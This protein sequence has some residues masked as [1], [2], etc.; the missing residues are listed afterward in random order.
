MKQNNQT[1]D[2]NNQIF[3]DD[4]IIVFAAK[5]NGIEISQIDLAKCMDYL[6]K[7]PSKE[8]YPIVTN[9]L[10]RTI[11][12]FE[13]RM[14]KTT[15]VEAINNLSKFSSLLEKV[16]RF[17]E[18]ESIYRQAADIFKDIYGK[19]HLY[20]AM[21]LEDLA[22]LL[23]RYGKYY[24]AETLFRQALK[25][26]E[27][28]YGEDHP[29][30]TY[31]Q[32]RLANILMLL[33][34][35]SEA[36]K[37]YR[38]IISIREINYGDKN[39]DVALVLSDFATSLCCLGNYSE[40]VTLYER[41]LK[42]FEN[43]ANEPTAISMVLNRLS[44]NMLNLGRYLEAESYCRRAMKIDENIYYAEHP[45]IATHQH[46]L[47]NILMLLGNHSEAELICRRAL[48][49]RVKNY[50]FD[51]PAVANSLSDLSAILAKL[52]NFSEAETL[53]C[54]A[55]KIR[56]KVFGDQH[57]LVARSLLSYCQFMIN[58]GQLSSAIL[59]GKRAINI[60][61]NLRSEVTKISKRAQNHYDRKIENDYRTL[62]EVL[63]RANRLLEAEHILGLLKEEDF[64]DF[65]RRDSTHIDTMFSSISYNQEEATLIN[66]YNKISQSLFS[67][68]SRK[69]AF[70]EINIHSKEEA[71][72]LELQSQIVD[73]C[74]DFDNFFKKLNETFGPENAQS[75]DDA[76]QFIP[77]I[78]KLDAETAVIYTLSTEE[79][80]YTILVVGNTRHKMSYRISSDEFSKKVLRFRK[81]IMSRDKYDVESIA[82]ELYDIIL[83][84]LDPKLK[85]AGI[86]TI[87][88]VLEGA[89]R[90]LPV[91]ALHDGA[92]YIVNRFQNVYMTTKSR[93]NLE[94]Q[95]KSNWTA[96]GMGVTKAHENFKALPAVIEE[97]AGIV[98]HHNMTSGVVPGEILL[99][100]EFT[101]AA[102]TEELDGNYQAVHIASHFNLDPCN[103]TMSYLLLGDGTHLT[104][105]KLK[106]QKS[107]FCGVDLLAFSACSTGLGT[108][109][110]RGREID[111]IG[112]IAETQ[113]AKTV[114]A[115][116]WPVADQ[117]TSLLMRD[118]YK[119]RQEG[120]TKIEAL[121]QAQLGMLNRGNN[122]IGQHTTRSADNVYRFEVDR[123]K[124]YAHP[125][126]W[127][128]FIL[129][130]NYR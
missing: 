28:Y 125:Y 110:K 113:G 33:D 40:S 2:G 24:E 20:E 31:H 86:L 128:P 92:D 49:I 71:E 32:N 8:A 122:P 95:S 109:S 68:T 34:K 105:D 35:Y 48:E 102:M 116:L 70:L 126:Y 54:Q 56:H 45:H 80:F 51:H 83:K 12:V 69:K 1:I 10:E 7:L 27:I 85:E 101:W 17:P 78:W 123:D 30:V 57:R 26:S 76:I 61:Q 87:L 60:L 42:I 120:A 66:A 59:L 98:N 117:S 100:D 121:R 63:I 38:K 129:I 3:S 46:N 62:A 41:A 77:E 9:F 94:V 16:S 13:Q 111:G 75:Y 29:D 96:L 103:E 93:E 107:I 11:W 25:I 22:V 18:S 79:T 15:H 84:Q 43:N 50:D 108:T 5:V 130:G 23:E 4:E 67:L 52:G 72:K 106:C 81:L 73:M 64:F 99:D 44:N 90:L 37:Y 97:L 112:Y 21:I 88:W 114:L 104:L 74:L 118:F 19:N 124:P 82:C 65:I 89:L 115:T 36:A 119:R 6:A 14:K 53:C 58:K 55:L 47:A 127:A 39:V 91:S